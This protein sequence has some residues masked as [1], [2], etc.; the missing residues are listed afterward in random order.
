MAD[1]SDSKIDEGKHPEVLD[2]A[3]L[4]THAVTAYQ[5]VRSDKT[6]TNWLLIDYEVC[7]SQALFRL[8]L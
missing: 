6:D 2:G 1:L 5:D 4:V 3:R 7:C 8:C